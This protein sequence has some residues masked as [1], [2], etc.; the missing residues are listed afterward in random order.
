[1]HAGLVT[2][3]RHL[4]ELSRINGSS[5]LSSSWRGICTRTGA[6]RTEGAP[7]GRTVFRRYAA[8]DLIVAPDGR[9]YFLELNPSGQFGWIEQLTG[10]PITSRLCDA[11]LGV[12]ARAALPGSP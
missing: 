6:S 8:I 2:P 12:G 1:V 9:V 5:E 4:A 7:D 11:L 3:V 10:A